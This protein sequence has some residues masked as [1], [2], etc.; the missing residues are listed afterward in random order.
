MNIQKL[1]LTI[2]D[3]PYTIDTYSLFTMD[4]EEAIM[5]D[6]KTYDD[7][8]WEYDNKGYVQAL[9]DNWLKLM[10]G[11]IID[12]V[13]LAIESDGPAYSPREYN[14]KTDNAPI[15]I[16]IDRDALNAYIE[17]NK[18]KYEKEKRHSYDGYIWL[19][20]E[21]DNMLMFYLENESIKLYS[22]EDY[23]MDQREQVSEYEYMSN[24]LI[25]PETPA[26]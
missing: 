22:T 17:T 8:E 12:P 6:G 19:G 24:T 18:E 16:T 13:I 10:R 14:F 11:N 20:E 25:E 7:Y 21:I 3:T 1:P 5:D 26:T 23:Y 15:S 9:A 2:D 4:N